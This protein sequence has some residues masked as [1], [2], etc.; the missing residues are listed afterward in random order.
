[1]AI[2][3]IPG[4]PRFDSEREEAEWWDS[5]PDFILQEFERAQAEGRLGHGT[6]KRRMEEI[7]AQKQTAIELDA[8]DAA[9]ANK[10]AERKGLERQTYLKELIH[11]AL[12]KEEESIDRSS[13]A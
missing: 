4:P 9:L 2:D 7:A 3:N 11:N 8:A 10:L 13:A 5:H 6:V 12:L 1:M